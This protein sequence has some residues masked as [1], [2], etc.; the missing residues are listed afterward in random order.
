M[1]DMGGA[2]ADQQTMNA[3]GGDAIIRDGDMSTFM[4][5]VIEKSMA[6]PV[7]VY[8]WTEWSENC[9]QLTPLLHKV[10]T[11]AAGA[12]HLVQLNFDQCQQLATQMKIQ[13]VPT[14]VLFANQRPVDAFAGVKSE[15][16]IKDFITKYAPDMQP[17]PVEQM[18]EQ[19]A[20]FFTAEDFQSAGALY[21]QAMQLEAENGLAIAGLAQCLIK[22]DDLENAA[23]VLNGV[24]KAQETVPEIMAARAALEMA[25]QLEDLGDQGALEK[26]VAQDANDH[27]ARFDLALILW[28]RGD[29]D[30]A[31]DHLLEI[32]A[33]DRAWQDDGARKQLIKFFEIVGLM[34]PFTIRVRKKLSSLLFV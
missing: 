17:S 9:K 28:G 32:V 29:Q 24:S 8:F 22:L 31:A 26:A 12:V 19:A 2:G 3:P 27:Q 20:E 21:S 25:G 23:T 1:Q 33:R 13:S 14:A 4:T 10:I 34:E 5:D 11:Q 16:E 7:L 6:V 15:A 18:L 30:A